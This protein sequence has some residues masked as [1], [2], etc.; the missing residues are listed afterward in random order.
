MQQQ[1]ETDSECALHRPRSPAHGELRTVPQAAAQV[2]GM[3]SKPSAPTW[4]Q[5]PEAQRV[6]LVTTLGRM[7]QA[8]RGRRL[9]DE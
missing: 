2:Q 4:A 5:L 6:R 8:L 1:T 7:V 3:G 9:T